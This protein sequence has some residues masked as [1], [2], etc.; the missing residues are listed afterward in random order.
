MRPYNKEPQ[1][2]IHE[3]NV[4][5]VAKA[6]NEKLYVAP[7]KHESDRHD[8]KKVIRDEDGNVIT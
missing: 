3:G 6:A 1:Q 5:R 7:Y 8:V 2:E 4:Y